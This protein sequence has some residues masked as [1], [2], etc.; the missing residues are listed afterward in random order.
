MNLLAVFTAVTLAANA[1]AEQVSTPLGAAATAPA[2]SPAAAPA[3]N[4]PPAQPV[5]FGFSGEVGVSWVLVPVV[6]RAHRGGGDGRLDQHDFTLRVDGQP[7]PIV[8]FERRAEAPLSLLF[9][10]DLSGSM[11]LVNKLEASQW[12]ARFFLD[13]AKY[14]D[15]FAIVTF[16]SG[17]TQVDVPFTEELDPLRESVASWN[18]WG[19]TTLHDAVAW[20]PDLTL[21]GKNAKRAA[22][23]VTDGIDNASRIDPAAAREIARAAQVPVYVVGLRT[24]SPY[25][26]D[27][28]GAKVYRYAD[29]LNLLATTTGGHYYSVTGREE[30]KEAC[31]A[32]AEDLRT[33][34]VLSFPTTSQGESRYRPLHVTAAIKNARLFFR[35]G[36]RGR[37][38]ATLTAVPP[39]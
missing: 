18:G 6:V 28:A 23:L 34:Y 39:R 29:L 37:P 17:T 14:G 22:I 19:K 27:A 25:E 13:A 32:I 10:Q 16:G 3:V 24:G 26:V 12:A 21:Q 15:E 33:Q 9:L 7:T 2:P 31:A 35:Q 5:D 11:G 1:P 38:P 36:Y 4:P 8:E 30:L 20:L